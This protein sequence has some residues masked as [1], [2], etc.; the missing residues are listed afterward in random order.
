MNIEDQIKMYEEKLTDELRICNRIAFYHQNSKDTISALKVK[1]KE[2]KE[3][4]KS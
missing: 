1:I 4:V 3:K 2:L